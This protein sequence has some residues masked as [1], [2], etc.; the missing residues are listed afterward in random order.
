MGVREL[1]L[2]QD[3]T[4]HAYDMVLGLY[5][6]KARMYD[7]D[8]RRF[9]AVDPLKGTIANPQSINPYIYV[10]N[11]P[12]KH[13]DPTGMGGVGEVLQDKALKKLLANDSAT[14]LRGTVVGKPV[15]YMM[16]A[17]CLESTHLVLDV[18]GFVPGVGVIFDVA[19]SVLYITQ[20][21]YG[22]AALC[23][24]AA[25]PLIGDTAA[26]AKLAHAGGKLVLKSSAGTVEITSA[27]IRNIENTA[28]KSQSFARNGRKISYSEF[29]RDVKSST[30]S[31]EKLPAAEGVEKTITRSVH[32]EIRASQGR[33][34][35]TA[36]NDVQR[37]RPADVLMQDDGRWI[38]R[39]QN[40]RIHILEQS[41]EI[42]TTITSTNSTVLQ[43]IEYG[44]WSRLS[45][46]QE[47]IFK[48]SFINYVNW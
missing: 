31:L 47:N 25:V 12:I 29:A 46:E 6:A 38:I 33:N 45:L 5:Y 24:V 3:Y 28:L 32:A 39:G 21:N 7:A 30:E 42:V 36:I 34:V 4:G 23:I 18:A 48:Q 19:N 16:E 17:G 35:A 41:G 10:L 9:M 22:A 27:N 15:S 13:T 2:V 11:N 1:D 20:G 43:K 40:G 37:A 8:D 26:A 14:I 44:I